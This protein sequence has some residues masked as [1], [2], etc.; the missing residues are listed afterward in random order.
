MLDLLDDYSR[1][2]D[3]CLTNFPEKDIEEYEISVKW[4][5]YWW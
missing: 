4:Y 1:D 2:K 5:R 3:T